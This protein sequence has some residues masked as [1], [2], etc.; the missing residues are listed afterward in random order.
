MNNIVKI[1]KSNW[2]KRNP[3]IFDTTSSSSSSTNSN[4]VGTW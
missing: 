3:I 4:T 2:V 1:L